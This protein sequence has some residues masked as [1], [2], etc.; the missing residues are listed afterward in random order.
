MELCQGTLKSYLNDK[1][2]NG[3]SLDPLELV[4]IMIHLLDGLAYCHVR[5]VCHRDLKLS[6]GTT[7]DS[8]YLTISTVCQLP[9]HLP[10]L[11]SLFSKTMAPERF[12]ILHYF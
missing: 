12:W 10:C 6:N 3:E 8:A 1:K 7:L 5:G 2:D 9:L 11:A 4:E